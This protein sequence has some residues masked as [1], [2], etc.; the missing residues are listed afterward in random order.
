MRRQMRLFV[1]LAIVLFMTLGSAPVNTVRAEGPVTEVTEEPTT[2]PD[3]ESGEEKNDAEVPAANAD[4]AQYGEEGNEEEQTSQP[5]DPAEGIEQKEEEAVAE[6]TTEGIPTEAET[7]ENVSEGEDEK[8]ELPEADPT[9]NV[10]E[11]IALNEN[12]FYAEYDLGDL[13]VSIGYAA[14][15][16]P[17]GTEV[18]LNA[19]NEEQ[20]EAIRE[21][22]GE[23]AVIKA[24]DISFWL[25]EQ[26]IKLKDYSDKKVKVTLAYKGEED[27]EFSAVHVKEMQD[28]NGNVIY[29]AELVEGAETE[30]LIDEIEIPIYESKEITKT[31][32]VPYEETWTETVTKYKN[33]DVYE[34]V[35]VPYE[36]EVEVPVYETREIT[37][38]HTMLVTKTRDVEKT[39]TVKVKVAFKWYDPSTWLGY[40]NEKQTYTVKETYQEP[41][42]VT[43]VV[44]TEEVEV[45]TETVKVTNYKTEKQ[46]VR[47]DRVA[48]GEETVTHTETKYREETVGTGVFEDVPTGEYMTETAVVGQTVTFE[49]DDFSAY[50]LVGVDAENAEIVY[51]GEAAPALKATQPSRAASQAPAH[52]KKLHDNGDGTYTLSLSV[53]GAKSSSSTSEISKANV[54]LVLD[55]SSSMNYSAGD[56]YYTVIGTPLAPTTQNYGRV[57]PTFYRPNPNGAGFVQLY[58]V[59][60][61]WRITNRNNGTVYN[62]TFYT[63]NRMW[64]EIHALTDDGKIIDSLLAQNVAGDPEKSDIIEIA[65]VDFNTNGHQLQNFTTSAA[66][67]KAKIRGLNTDSGTNWEDALSTANDYATAIKAS[68][69]DEPVYVIFMTDGQPT[70]PTGAV[71]TSWTAA[72]DDARA[73]IDPTG[74]VLYG[75]FTWGDSGNVHYLSSLIHY[76]YVGS[77]TSNTDLEPAYQQYYK[78][79]DNVDQL[80]EALSQI[81][82]EIT[83]GVGYT[84][85]ELTDGVTEMTNSSVKAS[86]SGGEIT[87]LKYYRSG[88]SYGT[89]DPDN[90]NYGTEWTDAPKATIN[91]DGEVDWSLG[92]MILEDGVTYTVTFV[93]WPKQESLN[94]VADLNNGVIS[95]NDLTPEQREQIRVS[96]THYSLKTNTDYPTV[97]YSTVTTTTIDGQTTTVVSD[98]TSENITNPEPVGLAEEQLNAVKVWDDSLDPSQR[99]EIEDVLLYLKVD[100]QYYYKDGDGNPLGVTLTE[101]SNWTETN[102]IAVAPGLFV[103]EDSPA[104]DPDAPHFEW[105]GT[106]WAMLE[107]G[108]EY[109]FEESDINHHFVLTA[110]TH[111]PMIMGTDSSGQPII[112]DVIFTKDASGNLTGIESV[113]NMGDNISATNTLKP[114]I[115]IEKK[116]VDSEGNDIDSSEP[117][118]VKINLTDADGNALPNKT[119]VVNDETV[120]YTIDYRIYYGEK[121]P[122]YATCTDPKHRSEHIYVSGTSFEETIYVGDT[123]RVV[124][125]ETDALFLVEETL[126]TG[127]DSNSFDYKIATGTAAAAAYDED[128]TVTKGDVVWYKTK[129]NSASYVTVTNKLPAVFYVYHSSDNTVERIPMNDARITEGEFNIV[130]ETKKGYLYG[131]YYTTYALP[132]FATDADVIAAAYEEKT[133]ATLYEYVAAR[134]G[135]VWATDSAGTPYVGDQTSWNMDNAYTAKGDAMTPGKGKVY[136]LKE[137]PE[138]YLEP[139]TYVVYDTHDKDADGYYQIK[140]LY[141]M[142]ATDDANYG[143]VGFEVTTSSGINNSGSF[144]SEFWG[145]QIDVKKDGEDYATLTASMLVTDHT[146]LIASRD[147]TGKYIVANAY[148]RL[149]PF[150]V[151]PDNVKVT[152]VRRMMVYVRNTRWKDWTKP[153]MNK[154]VTAV[155]AAYN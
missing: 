66:E 73:L 117:F 148:Y 136:Y 77:G 76:A 79:A 114:G 67:L 133:G 40:K 25:G 21:Q 60:N 23:D 12:D 62:G 126:P 81:I 145:A 56:T 14:E 83:V 87:G 88:G 152:S 123:I 140:K 65:L 115:N 9:E 31:E 6:G 154:V 132:G 17:E 139:A 51:K 33:V 11:V 82:H 45:G 26:E 61:A 7:G 106:Q 22:F 149:L 92:N 104:Y 19:P 49:A 68:Q 48:D 155:K 90:G 116:V 131:G 55:T 8:E 37:E 105:E 3:A 121:N 124:N 96:G 110:Y 70:N 10:Q 75:L 147:I 113:S 41:V 146:G 15:T 95:Y 46:Y 27:L 89:A 109:V 130:N 64:A 151:T 30:D 16:V 101:E 153:G 13:K 35:Q 111:H 107:V 102:Y 38:D 125:I 135:G 138:A 118:T 36:E 91:S 99:E 2:T 84:N 94:L 63:N 78:T 4:P 127:Y 129:G 50:A 80:I 29:A 69:P 142:T 43:V 85:V 128:D 44:G 108:H 134:T 120:N 103:T 97:T 100:N 144:G 18:R 53:T 28:E 122:E 74:A 141:Q 72:T 86:T 24:V 20:F 119:T 47:T 59:N 58:Y 137:V 42:T 57:T 52:G 93:V 39:R 150:F 98:P 34:D 5:S 71:D 1:T 54:V 112:K 143:S 32:Q